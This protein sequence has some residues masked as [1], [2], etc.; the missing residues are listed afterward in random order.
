[1]N[2]IF[3]NARK[4]RPEER[5]WYEMMWGERKARDYLNHFHDIRK[6]KERDRVKKKGYH[7]ITPQVEWNIKHWGYKGIAEG[8]KKINEQYSDVIQTKH[9]VLSCMLL[10]M[11][12]LEFLRNLIEKNEI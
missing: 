7:K 9:P 5:E 6:V 3:S 10:K 8:F 2:E 12:Y 4:P 1:M 11:V